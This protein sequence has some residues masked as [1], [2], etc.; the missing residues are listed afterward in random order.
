MDI[1]SID[2]NELDGYR[3]NELLVCRAKAMGEIELILL[4][5]KTSRWQKHKLKWVK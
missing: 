3:P 1:D 5:K 2:S 4:R